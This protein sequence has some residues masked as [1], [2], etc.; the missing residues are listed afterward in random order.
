M[1]LFVDCETTGLPKDWGAPSSDAASWP[2]LVQLGWLLSEERI[3]RSL[4][5][6][7]VPPPA[8]VPTVRTVRPVGFAVPADAVAI[9][10]ITT[11]RATAEGVDL[12]GV[13][14]E[15]AAAFAACGEVVAHNARFDRKILEAEFLRL[16]RPVPWA[17][18]KD[19]WKCTM[20]RTVRMCA[21]RQP[22]GSGKFPRIDELY[23]RLFSRRPDSLAHL[24]G[25][26]VEQLCDCWR[27]LRRRGVM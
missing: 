15:F 3:V 11:E 24:A 16:G 12:A 13:L 22:N 4:F 5:R 21:A 7:K 9:H 18:Q 23:Q 19:R 1:I 8:P 2:R 27:E 10:G 14:D 20:L 25:N 6:P 17:S 26:H